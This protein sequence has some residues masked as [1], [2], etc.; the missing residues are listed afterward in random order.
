[1]KNLTNQQR[2]SLLLL[3]VSAAISYLL[4]LFP[5]GNYIIWP[6]VILTT[7]IHEIGHGLTVIIV[8]GDFKQLLIHSNASGAAVY[9]GVSG[10][11]ALASVAAAGLLAPSI[12]GGIFILSGASRRYSIYVCRILIVM[13]LISLLFWVRSLYGFL[14]ISAMSI[15]FFIIATKANN[16][17]QQFLVQFLGVQMLVDTLSRTSRYLFTELVGG[18]IKLQH[19]DTSAIA[20]QL[21]GTY[22]L[23]GGLLFILCMAI[24]VLSIRHAY[25]RLQ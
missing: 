18:D 14:M 1:M 7:Y 16:I 15:V 5:F 25:F 6:F 10:N 21:G 22:W 13:M 4:P 2:L 3:I 17:W 11:L 24:F 23:W 19:S 20:L 8:G 12:A 9:S